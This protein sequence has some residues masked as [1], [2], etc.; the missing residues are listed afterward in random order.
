[1]AWK[2]DASSWKPSSRFFMMRRKRFIFAGEKRLRSH[3]P[4]LSRGVSFWGMPRRRLECRCQR[5]ERYRYPSR[6]RHLCAA[7]A[8]ICAALGLDCTTAVGCY[9]VARMACAATFQQQVRWLVTMNRDCSR[10]VHAAASRRA[11]IQAELRGSCNSRVFSP[12]IEV[13]AIARPPAP[14]RA[15]PAPLTPS[16]GSLSPPPGWQ[17]APPGNHGP[18][19]AAARGHGVL[20]CAG[21]AP[22]G[23]R[24]RL[25]GL[26]TGVPRVI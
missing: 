9:A 23:S 8:L 24:R 22:S 16:L 13:R 6:R 12:P 17:P 20:A 21:R 5:A 25:P 4:P 10:C 26:A 14:S 15:G 3:S 1:M 7:L 18:R 2:S 19:D 11:A